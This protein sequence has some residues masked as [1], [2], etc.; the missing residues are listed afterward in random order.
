MEK[1]VKELAELLLKNNFTIGTA[2]S[3]TAGLISASIAS[4]SGASRYH[5]GGIITYA[6]YLKEKLL[7][8]GHNTIEQHDVVSSKVAMQMALGGLYKLDADVCIAITGY[9]GETGGNEKVPRGTIWI[10]VGMMGDDV[11]FR[12]KKLELHGTRGENI[13]TCVKEA[14]TLA[15]KTI[16]N[17]E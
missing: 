6:T 12:Y 4:I 13:E 11:S 16:K 9:A 3:C 7:D 2:E 10:C 5:R 1:L 17:E 15:I 14:L 8:V